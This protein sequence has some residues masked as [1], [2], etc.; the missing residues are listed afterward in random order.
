MPSYTGRGTRLTSTFTE[1]VPT[2][3]TSRPRTTAALIPGVGFSVE[4]GIYLEGEFGMR[5]EV[6]VYWGPQGPE[7]TTAEPQREVFL[8]LDEE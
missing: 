6:D 1:A 3:T 8:L 4:P 2:S 5:T 7:V